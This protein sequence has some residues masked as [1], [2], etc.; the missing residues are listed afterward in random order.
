ARRAGRTGAPEA[1]LL[2]TAVDGKYDEGAGDPI[3]V[4]VRDIQSAETRTVA[5]TVEAIARAF[6]HDSGGVSRLALSLC[7]WQ[8]DVKATITVANAA[9]HKI[10]DV[11]PSK[12]ISD[13]MFRKFSRAAGTRATGTIIDW[14]LHMKKAER[15]PVGILRH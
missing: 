13:D 10:L 5:A 9:N 11:F 3:T 4:I 14:S 6:V 12:T 2:L 1:L 15:A 7:P 8:E